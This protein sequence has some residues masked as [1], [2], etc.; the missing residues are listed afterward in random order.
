M[1]LSERDLEELRA[2][3]EHLDR[4]LLPG[5]V[6]E[7]VAR[8]PVHTAYVPADR[9]GAGTVED[10]GG[11][12]RDA[13]RDHG[14]PAG[15]PES[16]MDMVLAK[17]AAEPIEDLRADFEDGYG[18]SATEDQDAL[19]A[20]QVLRTNAPPFFGLRCKS[21]EPATVD[22]AARTLDAFLTGLGPP[23]PGFVITF[24][25]ATSA[26]HADVAV[27]LCRQLEHA[28]GLP[29]GALRFELQVETP[30]AVLGPDGR[31]PLPEMIVRSH[32]RLS[33]FHYGTYDYSTALGI[34]PDHQSLDHP[35]ADHA[36]SVM[37]VA[38]AGTGVH[39]SDG[40]SNV[41]P[42]G[43]TEE[44]HAAWDLHA[45]LVRR[46]LERGI[47]QGWDLHP[48]QLVTRFA[49]TFQFYL[50]GLPRARRRLDDY[51]SRRAS[52][53]LDEPATARAIARFLLRGLHCGALRP[54]DLGHP[55]EDL[56][57]L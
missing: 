32:G 50:D 34:A 47:H 30:Q 42:V 24:P 9:L 11:A 10:W 33:G 15:F 43:S 3:A 41:L 5:Q 6:E 39:V 45:R 36:K 55:T 46:S 44:V 2:A 4:L 51:L 56:E 22:R 1:E 27:L 26:A 57:A 38:V 19:S 54:E 14:P 25:K 29:D 17:L 40:S 8:R 48:A 23:P 7:R 37:Q 21:L 18:H 12:A 20:G 31:S 13:V 16:T 52:G 28:H 49:A 35:V 53:I